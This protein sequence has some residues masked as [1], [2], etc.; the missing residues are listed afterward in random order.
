[1]NTKQEVGWDR[2]HGQEVI[3]GVNQ[4]PLSAP[5]CPAQLDQKPSSDEQAETPKFWDLFFPSL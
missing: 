3:S 5:M 4:A 1:M 2:G